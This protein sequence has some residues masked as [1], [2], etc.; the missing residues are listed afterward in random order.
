MK[1]ANFSHSFGKDAVGTFTLPGLN[2]QIYASEFEINLGTISSNLDS[3]DP[4]RALNFSL[5]ANPFEYGAYVNSNWHFGAMHVYVPDTG[6]FQ[7]VPVFSAIQS[8]T[9][10]NPINI[11]VSGSLAIIC[12][13]CSTIKIYKESD[14]DLNAP[15]G[16]DPLLGVGPLSGG[17]GVP[18][19][20]VNGSLSNV[21]STPYISTNGGY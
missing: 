1:Y 8:V 5:I 20:I 13:A 4:V 18:N 15:W 7:T 11:V 10:G 12:T 17:T 14:N 3:N 21:T 9:A 16:V 19:G 2:S 6:F